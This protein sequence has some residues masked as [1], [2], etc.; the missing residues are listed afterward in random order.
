MQQR[1]RLGHRS[2]KPGED[3]VSQRMQRQ[4]VHQLLDEHKRQGHEL[5]QQQIRS[6]GQL[7]KIQQTVQQTSTSR[8]ITSHRFSPTSS[9]SATTLTRKPAAPTSSPM[10]QLSH[11]LR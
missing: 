7:Q 10:P 11:Q 2:L 5:N 6:D 4:H 3:P 9:D 8:V 1:R